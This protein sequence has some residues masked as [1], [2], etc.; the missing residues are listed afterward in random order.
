MFVTYEE[1]IQDR[2]INAFEA[3]EYPSIE[4]QTRLNCASPISD[5]LTFHRQPNHHFILSAIGTE[6]SPTQHLQQPA[7]FHEKEAIFRWLSTISTTTLP[8]CHLLQGFVAD[9]CIP[10]AGINSATTH[11]GSQVLRIMANGVG[12]T[13]RYKHEHMA[14]TWE[15]P[16]TR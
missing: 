8:L 11:A 15:I 12:S 14:P 5:G 2:E 9:L 6:G 4:N 10:P 13:S 3:S 7:T 16:T 1:L